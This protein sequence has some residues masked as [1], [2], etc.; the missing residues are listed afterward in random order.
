M[1]H[2]NDWDTVNQ[3]VNDIL[4]HGNSA[5]RQRQIYQETGGFKAV[6]DYLIALGATTLAVA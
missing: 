6:V 5:Q 3:Q 2:H 4:T 1:E